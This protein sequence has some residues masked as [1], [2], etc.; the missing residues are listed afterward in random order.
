MKILQLLFVFITLLFCNVDSYKTKRQYKSKYKPKAKP[1]YVY[2]LSLKGGKKY[3]GLTQNLKQRMNA[4]FS[5]NGAKWTQKHKPEYINHIQ[6]YKSYANAK[7][8]ETAV[9]H[10]MKNY[11]GEDK[12][13]GAGHTKSY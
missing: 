10:E 7:K 13:R 1:T 12:V 5:G 2:S 4:H 9:Y 8:A 11:Y 3:V 6:E